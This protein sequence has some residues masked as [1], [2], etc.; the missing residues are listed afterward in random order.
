[1]TRKARASMG[2]LA[3]VL[4]LAAS[5]LCQE[6]EN[7]TPPPILYAHP[8]LNIDTSSSDHLLGGVDLGLWMPI[9][10]DFNITAD[11]YFNTGG[12]G[13]STALVN[14]DYPL[15]ERTLVRGGAGLIRDEF[16][17]SLKLHRQCENF[18][19]GAFAEHVEGDWQFGAMLTKR[20]DWG[21]RL[22]RPLKAREDTRW[23]SS[24]G[25][26]GSLGASAG[27]VYQEADG[28]SSVTT[29][30]FFFPT[31]RHSW[32]RAGGGAQ[33]TFASGEEFLPPAHLVWKYDAEGPVRTSPAISEGIAYVGSQDGWLYAV[34]LDTG[35]RKWR[36]PANAPITSGPTFYDGHIYF[37]TDAGDLFCVKAPADTS[38]PAGD[39]AWRFDAGEAVTSSPLV[40][41][42]GLIFFGAGD[43]RFYALNRNGAVKWTRQTD[44]AIIAA[45][46]KAVWTIPAGIDAN[47]EATE[48]A[49]A[50]LCASTD[51]HLYAFAEHSG[52]RV[53][54]LDTRAPLTAAPAILGETI[55]AA[56]YAGEVTAI[57]VPSGQIRWMQRVPGRVTSSP[58]VDRNNLVVVTRGG[59]IFG[60]SSRDG[61]EKWRTRLPAAI[62]ASGTLVQDSVL[63]VT[64]RDG[65]LRALS[66]DDGEVVWQHFIGEPLATSPTI[67]EGHLLVGGERAG[68][69]AYRKGKGK[70]IQLASASRHNPAAVADARPDEPEMTAKPQTTHAET[71]VAATD[72]AN[73]GEP[74]ESPSQSQQSRQETYQPPQDFPA[75]TYSM[76]KSPTTTEEASDEPQA[77]TS[78]QKETSTAAHRDAE[79]AT[80]PAAKDS[81]EIPS[82]DTT[83]VSTAKATDTA[84][85]RTD[86]G[87][88]LTL[89]TDPTA[90]DEPLLVSNRSHIFIGGA[91]PDSFSVATF[92]VNGKSVS[93]ED[94]E[95]LHREEFE[96]PGMYLVRMTATSPQG[97]SSERVRRVRVL[98]EDAV[99][100][101]EDVYIHLS[102]DDSGTVATIT[103]GAAEDLPG[104]V[105]ICEIQKPNGTIIRRWS[106]E[107]ITPFRFTWDG[108]DIEGNTVE[109]G[110]YEL[111]TVVR[112][113]DQV[114]EEIRQPLQVRQ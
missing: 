78:S 85:A 54:A 18:G 36:F 21:I 77:A 57:D 45:P 82:D 24:G 13:H 113:G 10:P 50:I 79:T 91:I 28:E 89:L 66:M 38:V 96:G 103:A 61:K 60:L 32:P 56:N 111:V 112:R 83:D 41:S 9:S 63:Y 64:S 75:P 22:G 76:G 40:T 2:A 47:V 88:H 33:S 73:H 6:T 81:A 4:F 92:E 58:S 110:E 14:Y 19:V 109:P 15:D 90:G 55:Y 86:G 106:R 80:A 44:G 62:S 35:K 99:V 94:G 49:G 29:R 69:Y 34:D 11:H 46:S 68:V 30:P 84:P 101:P 48:K 108:T 5:A 97:A 8:H 26:V 12:S 72:D 102:P 27:F 104:A 100:A 42:S 67:A 1:M 20:I 23:T 114:V 59:E 53:W 43:G 105:L 52:E 74:D 65:H 39:L 17:Y 7:V 37:G 51:G 71:S 3:L 98:Q 70:S 87:V 31:H 16:G 93:V 107:K 95:F 25:S